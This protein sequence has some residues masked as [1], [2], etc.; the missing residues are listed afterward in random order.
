VPDVAVN[1]P[2][3]GGTDDYATI[4]SVERLAALAT[5]DPDLGPGQVVIPGATTAAEWDGI[6][7][8]TETYRRDAILDYPDTADEATLT[9]L[10]D[11]ARGRGRF[12]AGFAGWLREPGPGGLPKTVAPSVAVAAR[13]AAWDAASGGL[14]Q[15]KPV[16]GSRRGTFER[17]LGV[18]QSWPDSDVRTR[19]NAAGVNLI[20]E[21]FG[22]VMIYGWRSLAEESAE[23]GWR[24]FGHRRLQTALEAKIDSLLGEY[25][26]EEIDGERTLFKE[27]QGS[28]VSRILDP[29]FREGSLYGASAPEAYRVDVDS[30]NTPETIQDQQLNVAVTVV[31]SEYAEEINV[32]ITKNLITQGVGA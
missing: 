16:A 7:S 24:N 10:A 8:H 11:T 12:G 32:N 18:S 29:Y 2:L 25:L 22:G 30:V 28:I 6:L 19:L 26:F 15:N 21:M 23:P 14:G 1:V 5:I 13:I 31:E 4:T 20:R 9:T 27:V 17:C 3:A